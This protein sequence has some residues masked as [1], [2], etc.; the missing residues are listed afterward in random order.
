MTEQTSLTGSHVNIY[1]EKK[2]ALTGAVIASTS[3]DLTLDT[4]SFEYSDIK[5]KDISWNGGLT[6]SYG[7]SYVTKTDG[8]NNDGD[9]SNSAKYNTWSASLT[10]GYSEKRQTNFATIGEGT[11]IVRDGNGTLS[12]LKREV[13]KSQYGTV[14]MGFQGGLTVDSS[15]VAMVK[16]LVTTNPKDIYNNVKTELEKGY[17]DA[18][19]TTA[20]IYA[21][22]IIMYQ[23][24]TNLISEGH[25]VTDSGLIVV[26]DKKTSEKYWNDVKL[27]KEKYKSLGEGFIKNN[28][29]SYVIDDEG[30]VFLIPREL[31]CQGSRIAVIG[32]SKLILSSGIDNDYVSAYDTRRE[33]ISRNFYSDST[34]YKSSSVKSYE[35]NTKNSYILI[36]QGAGGSIYGLSG[37]AGYYQLINPKTADYWD[38]KYFSGGIG[39][40]ASV[41]GL[42]GDLAAQVELGVFKTDKNPANVSSSSVSISGHASA[43]WHGISGQASTTL[44]WDWGISA[45]YSPGIGAGVSI[46]YTNSKMIGSGNLLDTTNKRSKEI[47]EILTK[48]K[49]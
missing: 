5:D 11:I 45:G 28:F 7:K 23:K 26:L 17:E 12:A 42:Y 9:K 48:M 19:K 21:E 3:N 44:D 32:G 47:K 25:F 8:D 13:S 43:V 30:N 35:P 22:S 41:P 16:T 39:F 10:Y 15:T 49:D 20:D 18:A 46:M 4:G 31:D 37:E 1:V 33:L 24:T 40:G 36:Q 14:D 34:D 6:G 29:F 38:F 27:L 2:T